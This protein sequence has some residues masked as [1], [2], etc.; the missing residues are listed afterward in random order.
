M[1]QQVSLSNKR[2]AEEIQARK[3][4]E[5]SQEQRINDMRRAIE[6][7]QREIEQ[8]QNKMALPVD[9]DILRMKIAKDIEVRH[10]IEMDQK[11]Q[12]VDRLGDQYYEVKRQLEVLKAQLESVK[13]ESDKE[14]ND[15][16]E[17]HKQD[18]HELMLENQALQSRADD[19]KDRELIRQLRR[20][21]DENKRRTTELL[22]E[23]SD[24]R[25]ERDLVKMEKNEL[26]MQYQRDLEEERN[27]K[28]V[29]QSEIERIGFKLKNSEEEK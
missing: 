7:K 1:K 28:R 24:L 13:Y 16:K 22:G 29:L 23:V 15:V 18:V 10:K 11:Q 6:Q 20:D 2:L 5:I 12:E 14:K 19:K 25:R 4:L 8:I 9:T 21:L 26:M 27:Q 17:K 3:D